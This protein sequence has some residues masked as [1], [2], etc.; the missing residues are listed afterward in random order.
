MSA[1]CCEASWVQPPNDKSQRNELWVLLPLMWPPSIGLSVD[2][3]VREDCCILHRWYRLVHLAR[4]FGCGSLGCSSATHV[5]YT[6]HMSCC[7]G[8]VATG[9][10]LWAG[11]AARFC[12]H[13]LAPPL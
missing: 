8:N 5:S 12:L 11:P 1:T 9:T 10:E 13:L 2:A 4:L 6:M 7:L 3:L